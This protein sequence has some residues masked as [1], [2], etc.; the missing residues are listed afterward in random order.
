MPKSRKKRKKSPKKKP[1]NKAK[2]VASPRYRIG[3][4]F[5]KNENAGLFRL[6][7]FSPLFIGAWLASGLV[8]D[9]IWSFVLLTAAI[10]LVQSNE[11]YRDKKEVPFLDLLQTI[12]YALSGFAA[13]GFF[14]ITQ[15]FAGSALLAISLVLLTIFGRLSRDRSINIIYLIVI[16]LVLMPSF[17]ILGIISQTFSHQQSLIVHHAV[18]G[19]VPCTVLC[20]SMVAKYSQLFIDESWVRARNVTTKKGEEVERPGGLTRLYSLLLLF[21]P[22]L[23][24][25][26]VPLGIFPTPFLICALSFLYA[27][28]LAESFLNASISDQLIAVRTIHLAGGLTVLVTLAAV[29]SK[30]GL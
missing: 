20:S 15:H 1:A 2:P 11:S 3:D 27:P 22:A 26:V 13:F 10:V 5:F 21:G 7:V 6:I 18:L 17:S 23:P 9:E 4:L 16:L 30:F 14:A 28:K 19:F 12:I 29:L 25:A 8:L 24:V